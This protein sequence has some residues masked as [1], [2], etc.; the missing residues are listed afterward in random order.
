M[1]NFSCRSL[2]V[3]IPEFER[4]LRNHIFQLNISENYMWQKLEWVINILNILTF[5]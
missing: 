1:A 3:L 4:I 5:R 2:G